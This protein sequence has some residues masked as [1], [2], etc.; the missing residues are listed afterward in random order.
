M[1][2]ILQVAY[3][4]RDALTGNSIGINYGADVPSVVREI[5]T[6][7]GF[8]MI[9]SA[10]VYSV[11]RETL[12]GD[13]F[14]VPWQLGLAS[15]VREV[16]IMEPPFKV[17]V[18][19]REVL[20]SLPLDN[21]TV[22]NVITSNQQLV[23]QR[24]ITAPPPT[25]KSY[26]YLSSYHEVATEKRTFIQPRSGEWLVTLRSVLAQKRVVP[27]APAVRST[28]TSYGF[29]Q[30]VVRS[31][32]Q[33]YVPKSGAYLATYR[34]MAVQHRVTKD[35]ATVRTAITVVT[36]RM[37]VL[38][39]RRTVVSLVDIFVGSVRTIA[40]QQRSAPAPISAESVAGLSEQ[41]VQGRDILGILHSN[42]DVPVLREMALQERPAPAPHSA[43]RVPAM[44]QVIAQHRTLGPQVETD[45]IVA[46]EK[47]IV[48]Q[49]RE[50]SLPG[51]T[52]Q[53]RT[54]GYRELAAQRRV[55]VNAR[56]SIRVGSLRVRFII[57]RITPRPIDVIDP[58]VGRHVAKLTMIGAQHRVTDPP[59][60]IGR[61]ARFSFSAV[62]QAVLGDV[63]ESPAIVRSEAS[64]RLVLEQVVL[65]DTFD[66]AGMPYS[67]ITGNLVL[68]QV[69]I[70]DD[71]FVDPRPPISPADVLQVV[72]VPL[73]G[74]EFPDPA[75]PASD[76][77][78]ARITQ[79]PVIS[80]VFP[81]PAL[82]ASSVDAR[83][84]IE[85]AALGDT[86]LPDPSLP[87][88]EVRT[89]LVA[90]LC[91]LGDA[92]PD[93]LVALSVAQLSGVTE[94]AVLRDPTLLRIPLRTNRRRP[95]ITVSIT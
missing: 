56:S 85:F 52:S 79:R 67:D 20:I 83:A 62:E 69:A 75:L 21:L 61:V 19:T 15:V 58:S 2:D 71:S 35:P 93:P 13:G 80:D 32:G 74:D 47:Q 73:V 42:I 82:P 14:A 87:V 9:V 11:T 88:S 7:D 53:W 72:L 95:V 37:L 81:D 31:R 3:V 6:G 27:L 55:M 26:R 34:A 46:S 29:K 50:V 48:V 49:H 54:Y 40:A 90:T 70:S 66:S 1:A 23:L 89:Q 30:L 17:V 28:I 65:G 33:V 57:G 39:S 78:A 60:S 51:A 8:G 84:V 41:V 63:F 38:I 24:R 86:T 92:F 45:R 43:T 59:E 91:A 68:E 76:V 4:T 44:R 10:D 64:A 18:S 36:D 16:L 77:F 12:T 5:L 25:V 94:F 22:H